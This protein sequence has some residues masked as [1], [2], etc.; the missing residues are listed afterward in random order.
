M[1]GYKRGDCYSSGDNDDAS[2]CSNGDAMVVAVVVTMRRGN[3][4]GGAI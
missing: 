1:H 4:P 2:G 3:K